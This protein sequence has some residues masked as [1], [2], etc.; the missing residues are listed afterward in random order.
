MIIYKNSING[1]IEDCE[2]DEITSKILFSLKHKRGLNIGASLKERESWKT[3]KRVSK[4]LADLDNKENQFVLLEFV[5]RDSF[6]RIDLMILGKDKNDKKNLAI[7]ELKGWSQIQTYGDTLLLSPNVSYGPCNHPSDEAY[8]Y[9]FIL[10]NMYTEINDFNIVCYSYL[11]NYQYKTQNVLKEKRFSEIINL[12]N[13]YCKNDNDEFKYIL[14]THFSND[15][16]EQEIDRFDSLE[17]KP[18]KSFKEHMKDEC[19]SLKLIGSQNIAYYRFVELMNEFEKQ[20]KKVIFLVSGS[21]GSGKTIVAFKMMTYL[22]SLGNKSYLILPGPEFRDAIKKMHVNKTSVDFI[23]GADSFLK[24]DN[25]II[26][27][28][29]KAT[30]RDAANIFYQRIIDNTNKCIVAFIDNQQVVNKKGISKNELREIAAQK[31]WAI[32]ELNLLEQFRNGGDISY[33]DWLKNI[34]FDVDNEQEFF[35]NDFFDFRILNEKDFNEKYKYMYEKDNVRMVS[36]WTQ[37]WNLNSLD[38][39]IKIGDSLYSWNPNWKWLEKYKSNGN[40][41]TKQLERLCNTLNFNKDKKGSQYIGYFNTVQGYEFD[42]VFVHIPK[43]FYLDENNKI[44]VDI[45]QLDMSEMKSQIWATKNIK[46]IEEKTKKENLNKLYFLNRLFVNL[47]RGTK[48]AYV[49]IEDKKLEQY[50][51]SKL[52]NNKRYS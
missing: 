14:K 25:L 27:E 19:N 31:S 51:K 43:L 7:I 50:I 28:A 20:N 4:I 10:T 39:N 16:L 24:A 12:C 52:L 34:L 17:Y 13:A 29:H 18:S 9:Y 42:Y 3:L 1:F 15:I 22:R 6:K 47:T 11:P 2:S 38:P 45:N 30:G 44:N 36:F 49:Y 8:T 32:V 21:A 23:R 40:K 35:S 41:T 26:D 48:G 5:I 37:T 46:N 33:I